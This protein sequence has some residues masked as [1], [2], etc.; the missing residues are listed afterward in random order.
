[1]PS[2]QKDIAEMYAKCMARKGSELVIEATS[3]VIIQNEEATVTNEDP[4]I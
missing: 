3:G 2:K 4:H 1:M